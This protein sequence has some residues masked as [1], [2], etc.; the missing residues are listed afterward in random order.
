MVGNE[1]LLYDLCCMVTDPGSDR[2]EIHS[3]MPFQDVPPLY[4][5]FVALQDVSIDMGPTVFL[6]GSISSMDQKEWSDSRTESRDDFLRKK[7]PYFATLQA[8]DCIMYDPRVLHCGSA[9]DEVLGSRRLIFN[10]GFRNPKFSGLF[11]YEGSLRPEYSERIK[12]GD[13]VDCLE[14][15]S[16]NSVRSNSKSTTNNSN[17]NNKNI[18][19]S[20]S[21][22]KK[23]P[24][25]PKNGKSNKVIVAAKLPGADIFKKLA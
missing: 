13:I 24:P 17:N 18:K 12:F 9:N 7:T 20:K 1:G 19:K 2:Q 21:K 4:S 25:T 3:D 6:P 14:G 11:G 16:L 5:I 8:G 23:I 22:I 10:L 15:Y